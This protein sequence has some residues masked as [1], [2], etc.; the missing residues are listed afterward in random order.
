MQKINIA[1]MRMLRWMSG[2]TIKDKL[3]NDFI[4][5]KIG[6]V[7]IEDKLRENHLLDLVIYLEG[8]RMHLSEE[9]NFLI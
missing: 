3:K 9:E 1:K 6:V 5:H 2:N 8:L 7:P 4:K